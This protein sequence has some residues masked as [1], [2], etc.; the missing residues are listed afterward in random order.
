MEMLVNKLKIDLIK[1]L[2]H[3]EQIADDKYL[4][5]GNKSYS[6]RDIANEIKNE[7]EFGIEFLNNMI[8]L[9]IDLTARQ[10]V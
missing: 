6:R 9:A 4:V 2:T 5:V 10:K 3:N 8:L 1:K 7:T